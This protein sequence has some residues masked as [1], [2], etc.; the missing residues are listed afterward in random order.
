M[1]H[2]EKPIPA[3]PVGSADLNQGPTASP[4]GRGDVIQVLLPNMARMATHKPR[5]NKD[6]VTEL[7]LAT[8]NVRMLSDECHLVSLENEIEKIKWDII[9]ISEMRR[10]GE[11]VVELASQHIMF[12]KGNDKKQGGVGFLIHKKLKGNI[13][14][15]HATSNRVASVTIRISKRYKIR[16]IQVYAPTSVSS[17]EELEEFYDDLQTEMRHKKT[18]YN[19]IMGDFNAKVGKGDEDCVGSFGYGVR[20]DRG[21]DLINF[22][23]AHGFKIMNTYYKKKKNRRWTWHSPNFE[24]FNEIDYILVDKNNIVKNFE[25]LNKVNVDSDH[26]MIRCKVQIDS[27]QERKRLFHSK[28][29]PLRVCKQIVNEF[30][31]DLQNRYAALEEQQ[32]DSNNSISLNDMINNI[33]EPLIGAGKKWKSS[34]KR[35]SKFSEETK[36][37]MEK[38]RNL[39]TPTTAKEKIEATELNKLIR[40]KQR[41]DLR[42][43]K[44]TTIQRVIE[45]GKSFKMAKRQLNRGRLQFTSVLEED[46]TLT[47]DRERIVERSREFYKKLY[48]STRQEPPEADIEQQFEGFP[49]IKA[50]EV[51]SAVKQSKKGKA[52]GPDNITIDLIDAAGDIINDKLATLF[53]E[54][55]IQ[56]KVPE[57]WNEAII[58]LLH[59]KGDQKNI[60]NYRPI[61]LLNNIYKLFTKIITNRITRTLEENQPREQ[62]GFR[63]GFST[64]DHLHAVNQL[65]EKC[66][67]YKIPLV[68]GLVDYN[69]AFDSVE[70]PDVIEALQ[71]QGVDPVYVNVLKHIYKQA[72]S[73]IRLHKDSKPFQVSRGVRQ[74]DT[75]SPKLF[76]ACLEK[77]FRKLNW[78][79]RGIL[80]DGEYLS[81]LRFADDIIIFTRNI[82]ELHEMLQEL[83]QASLEVGLSMNFKKTKIMCNKHAE[84]TNRKITID[85]NEIEEVDHYIYLGQR[86]SMQTA[87]KEHEIKRRITLGWQAFGRASAIFKN[88]EIPTCLKRQVYN[89][90]IIPTVTYGSETWNLTKVQTMKLRS[91]QRAHERIMLNITWRDHKTAEWIREQTKLRD[92]LETI[93]KAKWTWA[94]HLTRRTDNRWTTKLTFWQ[95]RGHT[96]NKGR[97]KFR[98]RDDLDKFR[99]HW[100]RDTSD[101]L[102]WRQMGKAYVQLRT[103]KG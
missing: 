19:V 69:K 47:T 22:A 28:P 103:F 1:S 74:G 59:K 7:H 45:Q 5:T 9:G 97:P 46:G 85:N 84:D 70:I 41:N 52:P 27:K 88:K 31:I 25:V 26:R 76:T 60:S 44:A 13:E 20:N 8:Y 54:C 65:I 16:I 93:S 72:K 78:S 48:S 101:R 43:H 3:V 51:K 81:H 79:R 50:W 57:I 29:E 86:I 15:F 100:H 99:K 39:K 75:S 64:I 21:D 71:E 63:R 82:A 53:N 90:C 24:T 49:N 89:Q 36:N 18:H 17:Q 55:L 62:A 68:V 91:M 33:T 96:R 83:N 30:K 61:S 12:N 10:P 14:E 87:S 73:F 67:E 23:T 42:K 58:I 66:A 38:R 35:N 98:W 56:S 32:D 2:T 95:P 6:K 37:F 34:T 102:R 4:M 94:G 92:I 77:V 80:I 11:N 40:K